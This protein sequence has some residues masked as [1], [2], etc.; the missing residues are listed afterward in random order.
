MKDARGHGS[1]LRG[2]ISGVNRAAGTWA[3]GIINAQTKLAAHQTGVGELKT[4]AEMM[5][6]HDK[7]WGTNKSTDPRAGEDPR[8]AMKRIW[9]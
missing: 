8:A 2:A 7:I 9:S 4:T 3:Q 6:E 1:D 5:A